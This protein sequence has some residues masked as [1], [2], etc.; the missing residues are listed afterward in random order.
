MQIIFKK[1]NN[2]KIMYIMRG[3][4]GSGKSTFIKNIPGLKEYNIFST[5]NLVEGDYKE[6]F[7]S[8][9]K[10][11]NF[12]PLA[13]LHRQ[14]FLGAVT[15][16]EFGESPIVIDN[17]N[18]KKEF[19]KPYVVAAKKYGYDIRLIDLGT[20][21]LTTEELAARNTHHV[22]EETLNTM[23]QDYEENSPL[24]IEDL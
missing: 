16:M 9:K 18:I 14:N 17:T 23:L 3:L 12:Q 10:N 7:D 2:L 22:D 19:V 1:S 6:F 15:A 13:D 20:G 21:G 24:N 11:E 8:M 4:P 5:D